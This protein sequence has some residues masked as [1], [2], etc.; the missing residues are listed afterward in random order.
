MKRIRKVFI[1]QS[2]II[3]MDTSQSFTT[4]FRKLKKYI[5][6]VIIIDF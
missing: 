5:D 4:V 6:T 2:K 1:Q 3:L